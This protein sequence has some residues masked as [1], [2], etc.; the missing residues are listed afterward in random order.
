MNERAPRQHCCT[1]MWVMTR[2]RDD[3]RDDP[4]WSADLG[5]EVESWSET[6][7]VE[8]A[9]H[10]GMFTIDHVAIFFCPWCSATLPGGPVAP[11]KAVHVIIGPQGEI[12]ATFGG[13]PIDPA[14]ITKVS[15]V[16]DDTAES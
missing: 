12:H 7:M 4:E 10:I 16:N 5:E 14:L 6:A 9:A 2:T 13:E 11:D 1:T 8:W 3:L 15:P